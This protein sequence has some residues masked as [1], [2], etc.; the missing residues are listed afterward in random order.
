MFTLAI[1]GTMARTTWCSLVAA[2]VVAAAT[3]V[4]CVFGKVC[5]MSTGSVANFTPTLFYMA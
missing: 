1:H 4:L 3:L 5:S 2:T